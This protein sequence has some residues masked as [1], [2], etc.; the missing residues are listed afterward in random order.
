[1]NTV[2]KE[3]ECAPAAAVG[4][5]FRGYFNSGVLLRA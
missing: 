1:M 5:H 3:G 4:A 2:F